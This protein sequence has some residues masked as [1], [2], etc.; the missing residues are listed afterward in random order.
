MSENIKKVAMRIRE[1][2]EISEKTSAEMAKA[3]NVP[4]EVYLEYESGSTDIPISVLYEI[5][6]CLGIKVYELLSGEAPKLQAYQHIKAG[7]GLRIERSKQYEYQHLAYNF[8]GNKVLPLMVT[9]DPSEEG[10]T[11]HTNIHT[12][13]EF[14]YC[15]EGQILISINGKEI[16]LEEGDSI[17]YDSSYPHG[18]KAIGDKP[19]KFIAIV[20]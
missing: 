5:S 12:G 20:I 13:Q 7:C 17:F 8:M 6:G 3:L 10:E 18:M 1:L 4:H 9:V 14:D 16:I 11:I 2:R 15:L 19:A